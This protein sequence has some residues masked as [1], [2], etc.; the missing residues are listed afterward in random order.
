M[1]TLRVDFAA[2]DQLMYRT[3]AQCDTAL[4]SNLAEQ[5]VFLENQGGEGNSVPL[6]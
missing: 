5:L 3:F 4:N 2:E 6:I 1:G